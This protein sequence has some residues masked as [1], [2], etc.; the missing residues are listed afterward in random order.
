MHKHMGKREI[1]GPNI[2]GINQIGFEVNA[3][4]KNQEAKDGYQ[5]QNHRNVDQM[6]LL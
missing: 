4:S 6:C 5:T 2:D 1:A 3:R